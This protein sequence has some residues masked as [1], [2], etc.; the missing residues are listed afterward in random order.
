MYCIITLWR[1]WQ[2]SVRGEGNLFSYGFCVGGVGRIG[3]HPDSPET[4]EIPDTPDSKAVR[5]SVSLYVQKFVNTSLI[6]ILTK[7][8]GRLII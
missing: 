1:S 7:S 3:S 6:S 5:K 2:F 4:P 8:H